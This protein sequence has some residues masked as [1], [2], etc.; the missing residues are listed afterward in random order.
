LDEKCENLWEVTKNRM[1]GNISPKN[2]IISPKA[3][4]FLHWFAKRLFSF[5]ANY[6]SPEENAATVEGP[7]GQIIMKEDWYLDKYIKPLLIIYCNTE[8]LQP[9]T[10]TGTA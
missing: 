7:S 8:P 10:G 9:N 2:I 3:S 1:G 4:T 6:F 5:S